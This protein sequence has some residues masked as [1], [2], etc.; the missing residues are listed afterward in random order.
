MRNCQCLRLD[1]L[2]TIHYGS[3]IKAEKIISEQSNT[4]IIRVHDFSS[5]G[6]NWDACKFTDSGLLRKPYFL[7]ENDILFSN[8]N[9]GG[10]A[11]LVDDAINHENE[12]IAAVLAYIIRCD[13][14]KIRPEFLAWWLNQEPAQEYF[15][16][17][18]KGPVI[19]REIL[20]ETP[21]PVPQLKIQNELLA[22]YAV[23]KK[24]ADK[25]ISIMNEVATR[26]QGKTSPMS[27]R[28]SSFHI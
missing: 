8:R 13:A 23:L 3:A 2:G 12:V 22:E 26:V 7:K 6:I 20:E 4:K 21:I 5:E 25:R 1:S 18:A 16:S 10:N 15:N 19:S 27:S 28:Y 17:K 11:V 14:N 24:E 9:K